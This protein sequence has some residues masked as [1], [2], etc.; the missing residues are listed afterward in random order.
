MNEWNLELIDLLYDFVEKYKIEPITL[1]NFLQWFIFCHLKT[2]LDE[3]DVREIC[4][5]LYGLILE[6]IKA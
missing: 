6:H 2:S 4:R 3:E 1:I 5:R